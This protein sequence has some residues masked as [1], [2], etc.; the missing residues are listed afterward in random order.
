MQ[1][2]MLDFLSLTAYFAVPVVR[3]PLGWRVAGVILALPLVF[4]VSDFIRRGPSAFG[5]G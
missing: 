2:T 1:F 3:G 5:G 4:V